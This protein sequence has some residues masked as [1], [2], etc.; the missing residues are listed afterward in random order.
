[1]LSFF[2]SNSI[3]PNI[4]FKKDL[5]TYIP[6]TKVYPL[7]NG[8]ILSIGCDEN[9]INK[10]RKFVLLDPKTNKK[11][12]ENAAHPYEVVAFLS[13]NKL[14]LSYEDFDKKVSSKFGDGFRHHYDILN[15]DTL[16]WDN[17]SESD[18]LK[19]LNSIKDDK[20][21]HAKDWLPLG[22]KKFVA[23]LKR[24]FEHKEDE[25]RLVIHDLKN[26]VF[27]QPASLSLPIDCKAACG[28]S[29]PFFMRVKLIQ[30]AN[31]QLAC[32][33]KGHNTDYFKIFLF[34]RDPKVE[35]QFVLTGTIHPTQEK[36]DRSEPEGEFVALPNGNIL[37]YLPSGR[38]FQVW[39]GTECIDHWRWVSKRNAKSN[40]KEDIPCSD[41]DYDKGF[42]SNKV[43][44]MPDCKHLLILS[45]ENKCYLFNM[46][47]RKLKPIDL[48]KLKPFKAK[49]TSDGKA[50]ILADCYD[51]PIE[52]RLIVAK[53]N[54]VLPWKN[55]HDL[56]IGLDK[57]MK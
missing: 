12:A 3:K 33:V 21:Y 27:N 57:D 8:Y 41:I 6:Y 50:L 23:V 10:A 13:E 45:R 5:N 32:K 44:A 49:V 11:I 1:M 28:N 51:P 43:Y 26:R 35:N 20:F 22:N 19:S 7:T 52:N 15:T 37:T 25:F 56:Q 24:R 55:D 29:D 34:D 40:S 18:L 38:S 4:L 46:E 31:G 42:W 48:G 2:K 54:K 30:L 36:F 39:H 9:D 47:T 16:S 17:N 14:L 53:F